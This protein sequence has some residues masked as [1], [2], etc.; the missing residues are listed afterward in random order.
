MRATISRWRRTTHSHLGVSFGRP[1]LFGN[2]LLTGNVLH[3]ELRAREL[4]IELFEDCEL[5]LAHA[6][7]WCAGRVGAGDAGGLEWP[8]DGGAEAWESETC[9]HC[10]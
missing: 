2:G 8:G 5:A 9:G 10:D 4:V 1:E 6:A 7:P 3:I